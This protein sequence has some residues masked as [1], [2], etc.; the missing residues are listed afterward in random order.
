MS[1]WKYT[2][3]VQGVKVTEL[4]DT[5][6]RVSWS[7]IPD[8]SIDYYTVVYSQVA[9]LRKKQDG[10]MSFVFL[11]SGTFGLIGDLNSDGTYQFQVFATTTVS[12]REVDGVRSSPI[13]VT[14]GKYIILLAI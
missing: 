7:A 4:C 14:I 9:E 6:V 12:G 11:P 3:T 8:Y 2:A 13:T 1:F 10:E 5:V